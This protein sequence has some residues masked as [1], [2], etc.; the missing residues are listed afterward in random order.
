MTTSAPAMAA[1]AP[2][3]GRTRTGRPTA[4]AAARASAA[5]VTSRTKTSASGAPSSFSAAIAA[6]EVPPPPS[7]AEVGA[8]AAPRVTEGVDDSGDVGVVPDQAGGAGGVSR[9]RAL[10]SDRVDDPEVP[11]HAT[12]LVHLADHAGLQRHGDRQP[13]PALPLP[14]VLPDPGHEGR[15]RVLGDIDRRIVHVDAKHG[16]GGPVQ[17]R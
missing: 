12:H 4:A 5:R 2:A 15:Q 14:H 9:G 10:E 13:A 1:A 16:V 11:G 3:S 17:R 6:A 8:D 7:T